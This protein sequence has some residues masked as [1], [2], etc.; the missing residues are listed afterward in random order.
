MRA[1]F[2]VLGVK[3][4]LAKCIG[5]NNPINV[6][7]ATIDGLVNMHS[8]E[9]V[10]AKRGLDVKELRDRP[11]AGS[12]SRKKVRVTLVKSRE[13]GAWSVIARACG[14]W[15]FGRMHHSA[16]VEDTPCTRGMINKVAYLL[17]VE[18]L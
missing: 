16:V 11:M 13:T 3:D 7:R 17:K 9:H 14:G 15:V 12:E 10:A 5:S 4:V 1:V 2:E 8:A 6:I 18:E